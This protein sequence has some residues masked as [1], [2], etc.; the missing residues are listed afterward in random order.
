MTDLISRQAVVDLI[1]ETDPWWFEGKTREILG[2]IKKL[3]TI[4]PV[5]HGKWLPHPTETDWDVCSV[6]GLG[7]HRRFHYNDAIYGG[8]DVE[9]SFMYCPNCGAKMDGGKI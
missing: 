8:Y 6:C 5:K 2:G 9:E 3:P 4:A 1:M 7:T